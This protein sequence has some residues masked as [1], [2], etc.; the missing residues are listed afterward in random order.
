MGFV[1]KTRNPFYNT[2]NPKYLV[3]QELY[4]YFDQCGFMRNIKPNCSTLII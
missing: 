4:K 2:G 3:L 1:Y